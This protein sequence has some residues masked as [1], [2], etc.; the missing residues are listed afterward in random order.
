M[1]PYG[2]GTPFAEAPFWCSAQGLA[3]APR[4]R[5]FTS[6]SAIFATNFGGSS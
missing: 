1:L 6:K 2:N 3:E 5:F 4:I